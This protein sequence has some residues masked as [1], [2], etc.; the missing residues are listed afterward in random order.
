MEVG[1]FPPARAGTFCRRHFAPAG[2][3]E[4]LEVLPAVCV[5]KV[6]EFFVPVFATGRMETPAPG[7]TFSEVG[8]CLITG[9]IGIEPAPNG[10]HL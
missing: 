9:S 5:A 4:F 3:M 8:G 10:I 6:L 7:M 1:Q 2:M